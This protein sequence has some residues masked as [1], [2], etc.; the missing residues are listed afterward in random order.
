MHLVHLKTTGH[1][2]DRSLNVSIAG[3]TEKMKR[4]LELWLFSKGYE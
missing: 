4:K 2:A 3:N 1:Y